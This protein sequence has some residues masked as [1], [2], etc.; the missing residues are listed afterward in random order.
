VFRRIVAQAIREGSGGR[1]VA[2]YRSWWG[3]D[4]AGIFTR[5]Q[6]AEDIDALVAAAVKRAL[7]S[8]PQRR[9]R[10]A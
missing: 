3:C 5:L 1:L 9:R 7:G 6:L 4:G 8:R 10:K 2:A